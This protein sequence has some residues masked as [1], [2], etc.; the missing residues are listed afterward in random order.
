[1]IGRLAARHRQ[2][3]LDFRLVGFQIRH[4][5]GGAQTLGVFGDPFPDGA[6]IEAFGS[7]TG[8]LIK[9]VGELAEFQEFRLRVRTHRRRKTARQ[10]SFRRCR[11][12]LQCGHVGATH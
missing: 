12:F 2:R 3:L 4:P 5:D 11:A 9:R 7:V 1:M 6:A 10:P 8:K